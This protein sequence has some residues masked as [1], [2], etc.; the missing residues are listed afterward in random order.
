DLRPF[1]LTAIVTS[2]AP[3]IGAADPISI[4]GGYIEMRPFFGPIILAGDRG[5]TF[6]SSVD[7]VGGFFQPTEQCNGDP[8]HCT[9]GSTLGLAAVFGGNDLVGTA[10]LDGAVYT[11]VG[12]LNSP[13]TMTVTFSGM[14][15]LPP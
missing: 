10:T 8:L 4:T 5:F 1:V 7:T 2:A 14:A 9:A 12:S 11:H 3:R 6:S 13:A 15:V